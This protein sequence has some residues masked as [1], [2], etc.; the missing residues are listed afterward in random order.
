MTNRPPLLG[1]FV[2]DEDGAGTIFA[3]I[4]LMVC[5]GLMGVAVDFT[6]AWRHREMLKSTAD[7][8]AHAGIIAMAKGG[9][10]GTV[11]SAATHAIELN[12][13]VEQY[14]D[15]LHDE[16]EDVLPLHYDAATGILTDIGEI[17][18]IRV[19]V[20]RSADVAN[21][22]PT[23][24]LKLAGIKSWDVAADSVA[25][26]DATQMC[27]N[28]DG[29]FA[30]GGIELRANTSVGAGGCIYSQS[31]VWMPQKTTF[32]SG[33]LV[34]MP[35]LVDCRGKCVDYA[36]PGVEAAVFEANLLM[37]DLGNLIDATFAAFV[38][39][40]VTTDDE[41]AF[42]AD[43]P[44]GA[45]LSPLDEIGIN[46]T[47]L[48]TGSLVA[49]TPAS[50]AKLRSVPA[51][52]VYFVECA[53]QG[54]E[55]TNVLTL[56]DS[57]AGHAIEG[58]A[59]LTT[60]AVQFDGTAD[61]RSALII[62][63]ANG[64]KPAITAADGALIGDPTLGC[65]GADRSVIMAKGDLM[66]PSD[67]AGSNVALVVDG[68]ITLA[69]NSAASEVE[70]TGLSLFATGAVKVAAGHSFHACGLPPYALV[71]KIS[72]IRFVMPTS[73]ALASG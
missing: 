29:I 53:A 72:V 55:A 2:R 6:N 9:N 37:P 63:T 52:L 20:Q 71:P 50:W 62:S 8:A 12:T 26:V 25:V 64:P 45:D 65:S 34:G 47:A 11:R 54:K 46:T 73:L 49:L 28:N 67:F 17:N 43:K 60:C 31:G 21:P 40:K 68:D 41:T 36:N 24:F 33:A 44:M 16:L 14:G 59:I 5:M 51:G 38:D 39:A 19:V 32:D 15:I 7:V 58:V 69:A 18:A 4:L 3:L 35:D 23:F 22:V 10:I 66:A 57:G 70:S 1:R 27:N 13:P 56:T 48:R 30:K 61:V 42:F